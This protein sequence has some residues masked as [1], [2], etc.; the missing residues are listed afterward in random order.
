[1]SRRGRNTKKLGIDISDAKF[2]LT[3]ESSAY[4][5]SCEYNG[6][7]DDFDKALNYYKSCFVS[8][9]E[10]FG[11]FH[12]RTMNAGSQS[13]RMWIEQCKNP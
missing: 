1:M 11:I 9:K 8:R 12:R 13:V 2:R 4:S 3:R 10:Q 6:N 7:D 5:G